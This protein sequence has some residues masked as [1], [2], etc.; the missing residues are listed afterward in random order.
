[1]QSTRLHCDR[2]IAVA[3]YTVE[4]KGMQL[5]FCNHHMNANRDALEKQGFIA[6]SLNTKASLVL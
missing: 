1:M 2:C 6:E 4:V 5:Y 3:Q